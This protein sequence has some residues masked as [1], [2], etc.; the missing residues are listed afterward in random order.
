MRRPPV[1][2]VAVDDHGTEIDERAAAALR[3]LGEGRAAPDPERPPGAW[4]D[5]SAVLVRFLDEVGVAPRRM[6]TVA[7]AVGLV[8]VLGTLGWLALRPVGA[9]EDSADLF[10]GSAVTAPASAGVEATPGGP[11][12]TTT[13]PAGIVVHAAGAVSRPGLYRLPRDARVADLLDAA[14]GPTLE[15]DLDRVNLAAP[16]ADGQRLY[17][18]RRGEVSPAVVGP[19]GGALSGGG[20]SGADGAVGPRR[21]RPPRSIS[22][23]R[24][25]SSSTRCREWDRPPPAAIV[26][27]PRAQRSVHQRRRPPR[28]PGHRAREARGPARPRHRRV[29]ADLPP[30]AVASRA[31]VRRG[32]GGR[33]RGGGR[34][35]LR[36]GPVPVAIGVAV[37]LVAL[38]VARPVV[39]AVAV[40]LLAS[41][42]AHQ[43]WAGLAPLPS[44]PFRGVVV[45]T[46]DPDASFGGW[47]ADVRS[48]S[49]RL[50]LS[51]R[52]GAGGRLGSRQ[53]GERI[54]VEGRIEALTDP[55][56]GVARHVRARLVAD[57]VTPVDE[58]TRV[59][60]A[61]NDVRAL[62]ID[63]ARSLPAD[64]RA[65]FTG[66]VLG[67]DR[68]ASAVV[69]DDFEGAGLSHL[70][71]VSGQNVVFVI[72]VA[73][74]LIARLRQR[75]RF[76]ATLGLLVVFAAVTRFEPSVMR[77]TAMAGVGAVAVLLGRP[78][79]GVRVLALAVTG[80]VLV[81][82]LLVRV[83]RLPALDRGLRR[84]H[85]VGPA[86][87]RRPPRARLAAPGRG[88]HPRRPGRGG[89]AAGADVRADAG[90]RPPGQPARRA[91]G[92][93]GDDVGVHGG[94]GGRAGARLARRRAALADTGGALV[95][96]RGGSRRRR[97]S[98]RPGGAPDDRR[99]GRPPRARGGGRAPRS[100]PR[101]GHCGGLAL[102]LLLV[103]PHVGGGMTPG[104]VEVGGAE[105]W[106]GRAGAA[107]LVVPG[108]ARADAVLAGLRQRGV[109]RLDLVVLRSAGPQAA[110]ILAVVS[111]RLDVDLVWAPRGSPAPEAVPPPVGRGGGRGAAGP[112]PA[113]GGAT[114]GGA[115]VD[116]RR[117]PGG[118]GC[119]WGRL[120]SAPCTSTSAPPASTSRTGRS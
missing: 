96:E 111:E 67:D 81:D 8:L 73:T 93:P 3:A 79:S 41:G 40:G 1:P 51:A 24:R 114:R 102:V 50:E 99:G 32:C 97:G 108:D 98:A 48:R 9:A 112:G 80:L 38:V 37:A 20:V 61:V 26:S 69:T 4:G 55:A 120:G 105:L 56:R 100:P 17:L 35:A 59:V 63:G 19:D 39:L 106:R 14:G 44:G 42:L 89:A 6:A 71:V 11:G 107:V 21:L 83:P 57:R 2:G 113:G 91:G 62:V 66:F 103:A 36:P 47:R 58:G 33:R 109:R 30:R 5:R 7:F 75:G 46:S 29:R 84:H 54:E 34:G 74:P 64:Q 92:G 43:A 77:A 110:A 52:G 101:R 49:G 70:L 15:T 76:V 86:V 27:A 104:G 119:R 88:G 72:A 87:G 53:A 78:V 60:Q 28:R 94:A 16:L 22:T 13:A 68:G 116:L 82:P 45:L 23:R 65:L 90:G 18:P 25:R 10:S 12:T 115:G 85:R 118:S 95:G 117:P 31:V